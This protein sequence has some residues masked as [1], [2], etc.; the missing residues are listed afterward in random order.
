MPRIFLCA[1]ALLACMVLTRPSTAAEKD[2][3]K[4][5]EVEVKKDLAYYDGPGADPVKHKLDLYLPKGRKDFPVVLFVHGGPG[6]TATR[7]ISASTR[8][9]AI[10]LPGRASAWS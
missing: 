3:S 7:I 6:G 9:S 5:F 8:A 2:K 10:P 4:T 1:L